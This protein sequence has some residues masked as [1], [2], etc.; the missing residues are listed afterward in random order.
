[1]HVKTKVC[2]KEKLCQKQ[3]NKIKQLKDKK[4][5][6]EAPLRFRVVE[7]EARYL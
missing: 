1:M 7:V 2:V 3:E 6:T 4:Q 5:V